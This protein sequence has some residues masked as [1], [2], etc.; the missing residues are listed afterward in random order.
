[1]IW[2]RNR[3]NC[4][5]QWL[6]SRTGLNSNAD[7]YNLE[8]G[9]VLFITVVSYTRITRDSIRQQPSQAQKGPGQTTV[10]KV[11]RVTNYKYSTLEEEHR[12]G[13]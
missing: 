13:L 8:H 5:E 3:I 11:G 10:E 6:I 12:T 4:T 1:M 9:R 7:I 2:S